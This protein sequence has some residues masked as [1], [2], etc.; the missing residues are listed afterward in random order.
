MNP[1]EYD[2]LLELLEEHVV[3]HPRDMYKVDYFLG[4]LVK[5]HDSVLVPRWLREFE[6]VSESGEDANC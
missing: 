6:D 5:Y 1:F 3:L 4:K 2:F